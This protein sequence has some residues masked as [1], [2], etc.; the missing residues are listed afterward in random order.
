MG[1]SRPQCRQP[2]GHPR[3]IRSELL[4]KLA[5]LDRAGADL[6]DLLWA[7]RGQ[8]TPFADA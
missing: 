4:V 2:A 3:D 5:L 8:L 6:R 1:R 7:Q